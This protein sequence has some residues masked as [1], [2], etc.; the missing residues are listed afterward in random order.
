MALLFNL[1][2]AGP[3][4]KEGEICDGIE[5][6][7]HPFKG[8]GLRTTKK[9][10]GL[11]NPIA[12][13]YGGLLLPT[14]YVLNMCKTKK[15]IDA[16]LTD[17]LIS[18]AD[19][20]TDANDNLVPKRYYDGHPD[21]WRDIQVTHRQRGIVGDPW[22]GPFVNEPIGNELPN[23]ELVDCSDTLPPPPYRGW[24]EHATIA[25]VV[26]DDLEAG[27]WIEGYYNKR[28]NIRTVNR[29]HYKS[30]QFPS[31]YNTPSPEPQLTPRE[32]SRLETLLDRQ[33]RAMQ[34]AMHR[35]T[36]QQRINQHR[37]Q[38]GATAA[39]QK[40]HTDKHDSAARARA[41]K[42]RTADYQPSTNHPPAYAA[43]PPG[44]P[45][46]WD[47]ANTTASPSTQDAVVVDLAAQAKSDSPQR[48][49]IPEERG[50]RVISWQAPDTPPRDTGGR[51]KP[52]ARG[53]T[54]GREYLLAHPLPPAA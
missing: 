43:P 31:I 14:Q 11:S 19:E 21:R 42:Q 2:W 48:I 47:Q 51:A 10:R 41:G 32:A 13:G 37:A 52:S 44:Q 53:H 40:R 24:C 3:P 16:G 39:R 46:L 49:R 26:Q 38:L 29:V 33:E 45:F 22:P 30:N 34:R 15:D 7:Q 12:I 25:W 18:T 23:A 27:T 1:A 54:Y 8:L 36:M 35:L 9:I 28:V 20:F 5:L 17:Y 6:A 50:R 4:S